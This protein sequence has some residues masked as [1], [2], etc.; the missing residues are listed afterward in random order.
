[1]P[2]ECL[3]PIGT[4]QVNGASAGAAPIMQGRAICA[5]LVDPIWYAMG[6]LET[7]T[8]PERPGLVTEF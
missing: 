5:A 2:I 7:Q 8:S 1:M 4:Q 3:Y 6:W